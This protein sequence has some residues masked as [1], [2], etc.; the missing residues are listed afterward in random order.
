[1]ADYL[2]RADAPIGEDLWAKIDEMV[3][4][5]AG[6]VL[7]GRR[8]LDLVGPLGWGV[9]QAPLFGFGEAAG[10]EGAAAAK[11]AQYVPLTELQ[12]EFVL[13]GKQL[14]MAQ[15]TP[16]GVDLGAVAIAATRL[17]KAED[18]A[19]LGGLMSKASEM[20]LGDWGTMGAPF[21]AVADAVAQLRMEGFDP[22]YTLV[23]GPALF[24]RLASLRDT[25]RREMEAVRELV[26][27]GILQWA[28]MQENQALLVSP[29]AWN[30]DMVVGQDM[31]TAWLGNDALD[32]Q[33]RIFETVALRVKR[34]GCAC[35]LK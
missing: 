32:Q 4:K 13:L 8:L 26:S 12:E 6:K 21:A 9:E 35:V 29:E 25:G 27:G 15:Q 20:P 22:P 18:K 5:V 10:L 11:S 34:S 17:A 28:D 24:A 3:M 2:M 7:V 31:A 33:F 19:I 1:M 23:L 14:V 30:V 16:F